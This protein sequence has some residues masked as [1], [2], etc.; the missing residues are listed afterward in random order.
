MII[1]EEVIFTKS[2]AI[3]GRFLTQLTTGVQR[4]AIEV[5]KVIDEIIETSNMKDKFIL[6]V[7]NQPL[8][9]SIP[10]KNIQIKKVGKLSGH[11][12]EQLE[13]PFYAKGKLLIN[14]CGPAPLLKMNQIVMIHDAAIYQ[15]KANFSKKFLL[16]YKFMFSVLKYNSKKIV[17]VSEFSKRELMKFCKFSSD[18]INVYH[19]GTEHITNITADYSIL[20]RLGIEGKK[21]VLAVSSNSPNKNFKSII[22]SMNRLAGKDI[23]CVIVGSLNNSVFKNSSLSDSNNVKLTGYIKDEELKALYE[24]ATC[25]I[26][27]SFYE[28]FG[29]PP[30]E[31]MACGCPV[32]V[33]QTSSLPEVCGKY[34]L[35]CNPYDVDD[36]TK[37]I[38]EVV[39]NERITEMRAS[40]RQFAANYSWFKTAGGLLTEI[41]TLLDKEFIKPHGEKNTLRL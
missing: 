16:W 15:N 39:D 29:L 36:I 13:L 5:L 7:P 25:F 26:Y 37:K 31:A 30:I 17:T 12:W 34:A 21:F 24:H 10:L 27:P 6:L 2:I 28:G 20:S 22:E 11:A 38:T 35:Y 18:Q 3:N 8:K 41:E 1:Y 4:V 33:S 40:N 19:L 9:T 14:L 23:E 32:V